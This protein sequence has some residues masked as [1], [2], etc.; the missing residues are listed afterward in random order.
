[1]RDIYFNANETVVWLGEEQKYTEETISIFEVLASAV[2]EDVFEMR[3]KELSNTESDKLERSPGWASVA[4]LFAS[5]YWSRTWVIQEL[6]ISQNPTLL[7]GSHTIGIGTIH[8]ALRTINRYNPS[9]WRYIMGL[10]HMS[11]LDMIRT[12]VGNNGAGATRSPTMDLLEI[13]S[14]SCP[15]KSSEPRDKVFGV[16]GLV[17]DGPQMIP[18]PSY[19]VPVETLIRQITIPKLIG[20]SCEQVIDITCLGIINVPKRLDVSSW[21]VDWPSLWKHVEGNTWSQ[22][23][24]RTLSRPLKADHEKCYRACEDSRAAVLISLDGLIL[25]CSGYSVDLIHGLSQFLPWEGYQEDAN[26]QGHT[27]AAIM[28]P[29]LSIS[30]NVYGS[31]DELQKAICLSVI[32]HPWKSSMMRIMEKSVLALQALFSEEAQKPVWIL[33]E[34]I[35]AIKSAAESEVYYNRRLKNWVKPPKSG[36]DDVQNNQSKNAMNVDPAQIERDF[37]HA[38]QFLYLSRRMMMTEKGYVGMAHAQSRVGDSIALLQGASVPIILRPCD[39]G[40]KVIGEAYVHGIMEGEF[41]R[42]QDGSTMKQFHLK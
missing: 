3:T 16:L 10:N 9:L 6:A 36:F 22:R 39:G 28:D 41:W 7:W 38:I 42:A 33:A 19:E 25:T 17:Y 11:S 31:E 24:L 5:P 13:L 34:Y 29:G 8:W 27:S 12:A 4:A 1:M 35:E 23:K 20:D 30:Q 37:W 32:N 18:E 40:Y 15:S 21:F 14:W 26:V 2:P